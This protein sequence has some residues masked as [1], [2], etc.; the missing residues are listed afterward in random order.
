MPGDKIR[1]LYIILAP[2]DN[3]INPKIQVAANSFRSSRC[4]MDFFDIIN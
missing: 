3:I 2:Q 1:L 4:R